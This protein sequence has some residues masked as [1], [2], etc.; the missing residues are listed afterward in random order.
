MPIR[1]AIYK[2]GLDSH[3]RGALT[4]ARYL[5]THGM[6]VIYLGNQLA[7][8]AARAALEEDVDVLGISSLSGSHRVSVPAVIDELR[9]HGGEDILVVLG[10]IIPDVDRPALFDA[11]VRRIFGPGTPLAYVAEEI[12][13]L[14][15]ERDAAASL[16]GEA[17]PTLEAATGRAPRIGS[18]STAPRPA[19]RA[20]QV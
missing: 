5:A 7:P 9:S 16:T 20:G 19:A 3:Y 4:V 15:H 13:L 6:E 11:G 8:A 1:L 14:V 10:G 12:S 18:L 2:P 17:L